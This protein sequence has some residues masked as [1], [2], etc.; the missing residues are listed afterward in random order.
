MNIA[1]ITRSARFMLSVVLLLGALAG[2]SGSN[3]DEANIS[4]AVD[5][6]D[7]SRFVM[8]G[9]AETWNEGEGYN[10]KSYWKATSLDQ[11]RNGVQWRPTFTK[12]GTYKVQVYIPRDHSGTLNAKYTIVT[13]AQT[14]TVPVNQ[15]LFANE[16]VLLGEFAFAGNDTE[17]IELTDFTGEHGREIAF[18]AIMLDRK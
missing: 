12:G 5:D 3:D 8:S 15:S 18:D 17:Y 2:C 4:L 1:K 10:G 7:S 14:F 11:V 13:S 9:P 6:D 16:W